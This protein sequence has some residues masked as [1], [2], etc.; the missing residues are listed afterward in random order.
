[1]LDL[2]T[3]INTELFSDVE[4]LIYKIAHSYAQQYTIPYEDLLSQSLTCFMQIVNRYNP[5]KG[6]KFSTYLYFVIS[7]QLRTF[8]QQ[9]YKATN[10]TEL[11]EELCGSLP[12]V[13]SSFTDDLL[14]LL[15][16][17]AQHVVALVLNPPEALRVVRTVRRSVTR[18]CYIHAIKHYLHTYENW[19]KAR[20][21][22][23]IDEVTATLTLL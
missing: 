8:C 22:L 17:D 20:A 4:K 5:D 19:T 16:D 1:M 21:I 2:A 13:D 9:E 7:H 6:T 23:A 14:A 3:D 18:G 15:T 10:Y 11:D 12:C